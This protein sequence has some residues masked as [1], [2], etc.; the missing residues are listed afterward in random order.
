MTAFNDLLFFYFN[1]RPSASCLR[2]KYIF[3][4]ADQFGFTIY[5]CPFDS[6]LHPQNCP[7]LFF[8]SSHHIAKSPWLVFRHLVLNIGHT[9]AVPNVLNHNSTFLGDDTHIPE[10]AH[11]CCL[12]PLFLA[13]DLA[14]FGYQFHFIV[15][16]FVFNSSNKINFSTSF[17]FGKPC[18]CHC[19][20]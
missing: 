9:S 4:L 14:Y 17:F 5:F 18:C 16:D 13:L 15:A 1:P 19:N 6:N 8:A 3:P 11:F 2:V 12:H 7:T 10:H 20:C